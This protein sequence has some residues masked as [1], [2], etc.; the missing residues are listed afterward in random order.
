MSASKMSRGRMDHAPQ[1]RQSATIAINDIRL[2]GALKRA[3]VHFRL[4]RERALAELPGVEAL[5]DH[6][7]E[8]RHR[9]MA[10]L[11]H[12]LETFEKNAQAAGAFSAGSRGASPYLQ[13]LQHPQHVQHFSPF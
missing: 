13:Y 12:H 6:F 3:N 2:Q 4:G 10:R 11:D 9:T 1:F 7:K 8:I 5:R